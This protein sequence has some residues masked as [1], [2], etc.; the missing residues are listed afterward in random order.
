VDFNQLEYCQE[1]R[2]LEVKV[3]ARETR[4][5]NKKR[6]ETRKDYAKV[7]KSMVN[8]RNKS[9]RQSGNKSEL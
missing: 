3:Y 9:T 8:S 2:I 5:I 6:S 1:E 7:T 4:R